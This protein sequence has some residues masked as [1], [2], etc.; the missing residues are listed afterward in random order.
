LQAHDIDIEP[1]TAALDEF[2]ATGRWAPPG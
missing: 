2:S 1:W